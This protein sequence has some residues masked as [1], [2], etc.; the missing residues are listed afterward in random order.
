MVNTPRG[1]ELSDAR[2]SDVPVPKRITL[3]EVALEA[4]LRRKLVQFRTVYSLRVIQSVLGWRIPDTSQLKHA[5]TGTTFEDPAVG[6]LPS[7][8][9]AQYGH[10][11]QGRFIGKL[12]TSTKDKPTAA[13]LGHTFSPAG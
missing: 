9:G 11:P 1:G 6:H 2:L 3:A 4:S 13:G 7:S 12:R 10:Q 8:P 5:H